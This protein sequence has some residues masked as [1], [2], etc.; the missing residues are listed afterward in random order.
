MING[1]SI[2]DFQSGGDRVARPAK[3]G[4]RPLWKPQQRLGPY[5]ASATM[6]TSADKRLLFFCLPYLNCR[7]KSCTFIKGTLKVIGLRN[8]KWRNHDMAATGSM[9][10][11]E[12][13]HVKVAEQLAD[14]SLSK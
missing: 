11:R 10:R 5:P 6:K 13:Y 14:R 3:R 9:K 2:A 7:W 4:Q 1:L 8:I 12:K